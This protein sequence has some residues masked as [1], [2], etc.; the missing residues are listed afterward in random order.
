M[1]DPTARHAAWKALE[2]H[3]ARDRPAAPA[4]ALRRRPGARRAAYRRGRRALPRLLQ[5]PH[6]RRD[7]AAC[8]CS[9]P[10]SA[11]LEARRDMMFRGEHINV[12]EDRSVLHVALRMPK[13][14][15]ARR[16]RRR[17]RGAGARRARPDGRVRRARPLRRVEGAH[18]QAASR[19]SSTSASAAP[20][21]AR[22]WPTRRCATTRE[23][24]MTFR[25][26]SNVDST[27][28]VEATRDLAADET[29]FIISSKTFGTLE[30]LTN[31]TL[32]ARLGRRRSSATTAVAEAL[33]RGVDERRA[34]RGSSASTPP[35]CS[36][37]G[38]GSA[39]ATRWTRPSASRRCSR[40]ARTTSGEM[41]AG[42]HAMDEHFRTAPLAREPARAHGPARGLV[43]RLLR[44][45][46]GRA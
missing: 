10:R 7:D 8:S 19:T 23:R 6:H 27:D 40:S 12:S 31:A 41:L 28:F 24:D 20:T 35:T 13:G 33:R 34:G 30:T 3:H 36:A 15:V 44:R 14:D 26:V 9:S 2:Q 1:P 39:A 32:G 46:D 4:R 43:R 22:S 38:T 37:S 11:R 5:E 17:R 42:F 45:A 18:R 25:F 21:S 16:R 29:L